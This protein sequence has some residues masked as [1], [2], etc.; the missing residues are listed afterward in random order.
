MTVDAKGERA[1][2]SFSLAADDAGGCALS[3]GEKGSRNR[4]WRQSEWNKR[5]NLGIW[6]STLQDK[7]SNRL[8]GPGAKS[9]LAAGRSAVCCRFAFLGL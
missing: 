4:V 8:K 7:E 5:E 9:C 3:R 6:C 2:Q 1:N